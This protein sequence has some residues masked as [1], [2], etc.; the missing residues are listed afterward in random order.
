M[1][2]IQK[3]AL[4]LTVSQYIQQHHLTNKYTMQH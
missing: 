3:E 4:K 2:A 1:Q